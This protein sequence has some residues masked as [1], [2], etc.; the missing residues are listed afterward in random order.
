MSADGH[1]HT[2]RS[3]AVAPACS[4][5]TEQ[6]KAREGAQDRRDDR[7][8]SRAK[9]ALESVGLRMQNE[10]LQ[11]L[12]NMKTPQEVACAS[13]RIR[14]LQGEEKGPRWKP[15]VVPDGA[16]AAGGLDDRPGKVGSWRLWRRTSPP[17]LGRPVDTISEV[18]RHR[19]TWSGQRWLAGPEQKSQPTKK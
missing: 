8:Q 10:I 5:L 17:A 11:N 14:I 4:L 3:P 7:Q 19:A 2:A 6:H 18:N 9:S 12:A 1:P 13:E 16:D 15:S